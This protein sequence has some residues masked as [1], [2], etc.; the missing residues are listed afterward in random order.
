MCVQEKIEFSGITQRPRMSSTK[1]SGA[2]LPYKNKAA[3]N[4]AKN[5]QGW[6]KATIHFSKGGTCYHMPPH[7][8]RLATGTHEAHYTINVDSVVRCHQIIN[9]FSSDSDAFSYDFKQSFLQYLLLSL[10]SHVHLFQ[11]KT[12]REKS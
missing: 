9:I 4:G 5:S 2:L 7:G 11:S 6:Q 8:Y 12:I 1:I 10:Y 3:K